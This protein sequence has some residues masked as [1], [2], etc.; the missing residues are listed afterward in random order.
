M[1]CRPATSPLAPHRSSFLNHFNIFH[2]K[3]NL[4]H[5]NTAKQAWLPAISAGFI[6]RTQVRNVG[7]AIQNKDTVNGHIYAVA[8]KTVTQVKHRGNAP[9]MTG[10]AFGAAAFVLKGPAHSTFVFGSEV[11]QQPRHPAL[12]PHTIIPT[13][14]T[15]CMR[16]V[17]IAERKLNV[18]VGVAQIAGRIAPGVNLRA[19]AQVGVQISYGF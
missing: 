3:V 14:F 5:E 13:T 15:Y 9:A 12:L 6:L 18:D 10:R 7:G 4:I 8:T 1:V 2:G 11:A 17:P 16:V 19:R